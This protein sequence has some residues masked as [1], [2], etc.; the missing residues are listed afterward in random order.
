MINYKK[1]KNTV[2]NIILSLSKNDKEI[3]INRFNYEEKNLIKIN[4]LIFKNNKFFSLKEI[5]VQTLNSD[6]FIQMNE[7]LF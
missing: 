2:A 4:D 5:H 6:F 7:K 3:K 1:P